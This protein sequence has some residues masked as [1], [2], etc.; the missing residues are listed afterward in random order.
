[1][2]ALNNCSKGIPYMANLKPRSFFPFQVP[3]SHGLLAPAQSDNTLWIL[4]VLAQPPQ[5]CTGAWSQPRE[6]Q[7]GTVFSLYG[8]VLLIGKKVTFIPQKGIK[9]WWVFFFKGLFKTEPYWKKSAFNMSCANRPCV[10]S[11]SLQ[12]SQ[13]QPG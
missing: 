6:G 11:A 10:L 9:H 13:W 5:S 3:W 2:N 12:C 1:M 7:V 8:T 4:L